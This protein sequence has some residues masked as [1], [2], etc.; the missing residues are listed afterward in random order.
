MPL[1]L[2]LVS[3]KRV[4]IHAELQARGSR[5]HQ[6]YMVRFFFLFLKVIPFP[7]ES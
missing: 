1:S 4:I 2:C 3:S 7:E 5:W 6:H